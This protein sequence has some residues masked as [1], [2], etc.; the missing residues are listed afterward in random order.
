MN[1]ESADSFDYVIVGGGAAGCVLASRLTED[2]GITACLLESGP[3]DT[4][5][6]IRITRRGAAPPVQPQSLVAVPD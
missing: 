2:S 5:P 1:T 6:L 3:K 4:H